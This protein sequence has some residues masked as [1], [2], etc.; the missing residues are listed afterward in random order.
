MLTIRIVDYS[1]QL[2]PVFDS[3]GVAQNE[4]FTPS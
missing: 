4:Y 1:R 3:P 2:P